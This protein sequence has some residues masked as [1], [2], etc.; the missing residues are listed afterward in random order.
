M[1]RFLKDRTCSAVPIL[2]NV[3]GL[4]PVGV[5]MSHDSVTMAQLADNGHGIDLV[6][7]ICKKS[8]Q[9]IPMHF[10]PGHN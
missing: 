10:L 4:C 6:S 8:T 9:G 2:R 1:L 3:A 5:D 7:C